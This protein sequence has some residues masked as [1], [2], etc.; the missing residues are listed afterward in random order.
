MYHQH[1]KAAK[2]DLSRLGPDNH[3]GYLFT[4]CEGDWCIDSRTPARVSIAEL[5]EPDGKCKS[6]DTK[7]M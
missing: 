3:S 7:P 5:G 4:G 2:M 6:K 1:M